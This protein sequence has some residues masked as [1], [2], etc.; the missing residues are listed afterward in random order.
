[1][2]DSV[3]VWIWERFLKWGQ[4]LVGFDSNYNS[5]AA[6]SHTWA[7]GLGLVCVAWCGPK[8]GAAGIGHQLVGCGVGV[9]RQPGRFLGY[10]T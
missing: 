9:T 3:F 8:G 4:I 1:M 7:H 6:M 10:R 2:F 5:G